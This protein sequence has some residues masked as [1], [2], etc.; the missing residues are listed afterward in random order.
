MRKSL[1]IGQLHAQGM[2]ERQVADTFGGSRVAVRRQLAA[3]AANSTKVP[4][5]T[6]PA[7]T[8]PTGSLEPN[9]TKAPTGS[10]V[11]VSPNLKASGWAEEPAISR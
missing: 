1:V 4:T 10:G 7:G 9:S 6:V 11:L 8:V 3:L 5:G 2:S